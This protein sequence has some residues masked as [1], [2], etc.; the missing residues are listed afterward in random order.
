M[1][2]LLLAL[3]AMAWVFQRRL[4]YFP[5]LRDLPP[6]ATTLPGAEEV[7][8]TTEDG[9]RLCGWFVPASDAHGRA[10]LFCNGNAG[11][12]SFRAPFA[13]A[14]AR[15][16]YAVLLFDYRGYAGN[17]GTPS[18]TG[19]LADARAARAYLASRP[20]VDPAQLAYAGESL[21]AA[22]ALALAVESPPSA[23]VLRSPFTSLRDMGRYH[24]PFL[25]VVDVLLADHYRSGALIG[26][27][28]SPLLVVAGEND[29]LVPPEHSRQLFE[30][31]PEQIPK[32]LLIIPG[33]DHNDRA[34]LD[35][36]LFIDAVARFLDAATLKLN[37]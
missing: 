17:P 13:A 20:E 12:R 11:D 16:G 1:A 28:Q 22:V 18:E 4:V 33:A 19:L 15:C 5:L 36:E 7:A 6:V 2:A 8:F 37:A 29:R 34:L 23:L 24:Y 25:P 21:G 14:L 35:G 30:A 31:A 3:V 9:L 27:L 32:Q 26:R 10:V